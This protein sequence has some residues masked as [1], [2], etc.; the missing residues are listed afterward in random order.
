MT[1]SAF[2]GS[3]GGSIGEMTVTLVMGGG[4]RGFPWCT[5]SGSRDP[6]RRRPKMLPLQIPKCPSKLAITDLVTIGKPYRQGRQ[7]CEPDGAEA[8]RQFSKS[9]RLLT[10]DSKFENRAAGA[11]PVRQIGSLRFCSKPIV[12]YEPDV[13]RGI[14]IP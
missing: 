3:I 2:G 1:I 4:D 9:E 5:G 13:I 7:E 10:G 8:G 6:L 14:M 11:R 12:T